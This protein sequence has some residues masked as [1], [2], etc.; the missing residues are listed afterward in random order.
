MALMN[1]NTGEYVKI[2]G[3][4]YDF[5]HGNHQVNYLEF[6]NADQRLRY[7]SG[8]SP[9]EVFKSGQYN[10]F[11][12]IESELT[13]GTDNGTVR[14]VMFDAMY[15]ALKSEIFSNYVDC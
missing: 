11:G 10:N 8:L 1:P 4:Q 13:A 2:I 3:M 15:K 9:Y 12:I 7:E 14:D 6:A 5:A